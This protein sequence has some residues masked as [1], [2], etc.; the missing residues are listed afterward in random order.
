VRFGCSSI[1]RTHARYGITE[2]GVSVEEAG[3]QEGRN[4]KRKGKGRRERD[5]P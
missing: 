5:E 1:T 4:D 2:E 3:G